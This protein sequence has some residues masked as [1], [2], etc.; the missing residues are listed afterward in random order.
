MSEKKYF[1]VV[2]GD[3]RLKMHKGPSGMYVAVS[4][5]VSGLF[6]QGHTVEETIANAHDA[7]KALAESR[8]IMAKETANAAK[9]AKVN[10]SAKPIRTKP[11]RRRLM[12]A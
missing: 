1:V 6:T 10:S 7:A 5:D 3:L 8:A 11:G 9:A 4:L 12:K 2:D